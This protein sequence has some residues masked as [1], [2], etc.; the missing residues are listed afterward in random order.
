[1]CH[2]VKRHEGSNA[3]RTQLLVNQELMQM[4]M[5]AAATRAA[6]P[7]TGHAVRGAA[8]AQ[9]SEPRST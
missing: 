7:G 6:T 3:N 4:Q 1:M 2:S 9:E 8:V 5:Y